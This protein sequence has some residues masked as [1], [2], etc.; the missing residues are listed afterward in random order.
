M[1]RSSLLFLVATSG[2]FFAPCILFPR[3][4]VTFF[5]KQ[6]LSEEQIAL[7]VKTCG[8][9]WIWFVCLGVN[10]IA[11]AFITALGDTLFTLI[12]NGLSVWILHY[13]PVFIL[14]GFYNWPAYMLYIIIGAA[15]VLSAIIYLWRFRRQKEH[16]FTAGIVL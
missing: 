8:C 10:Q 14:I 1:L 7:L 9:L 16:L 11:F 13:I 6:P 5:V 4:V 12:Y 3:E 15:N 2:L